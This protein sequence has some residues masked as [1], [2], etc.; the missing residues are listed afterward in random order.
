MN[1]E[2][3]AKLVGAASSQKIEWSY[4]GHSGCSPVLK[5]NL[6]NREITIL[7]T[8]EM[9]GAE[10]GS[11]QYYTSCSGC[12]GAGYI[13][14]NPTKVH[15]EQ[16]SWYRTDAGSVQ[17][18]IE[19]KL[20]PGWGIY[21]PT[22][23]GNSDKRGFAPDQ[24]D[25][26]VLSNGKNLLVD[27]L[28]WISGMIQELENGNIVGVEKKFHYLAPQHEQ[29]DRRWERENPVE[30][31]IRACDNVRSRAY[32]LLRFVDLSNVSSWTSGPTSWIE[33]VAGLRWHSPAEGYGKPQWIKLGFQDIPASYIDNLGFWDE[34]EL[35]ISLN[36]GWKSLGEGFVMR[37][38]GEK[39]QLGYENNVPQKLYEKIDEAKRGGMYIST[40]NYWPLVEFELEL[41]SLEFY[42][43]VPAAL[44]KLIEG[45]KNKVGEIRKDLFRSL[46][47][48]KLR[49]EQGRDLK[50]RMAEHSELVVTTED[51]FAVGNCVPG[52]EE[53]LKRFSLE[54]PKTLGELLAHRSIDE[55]LQNAYFRRVIER[56][57]NDGWSEQVAE[58][59]Y[60]AD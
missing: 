4:D 12:S 36:R 39:I 40:S 47:S 46:H 28:S 6:E 50:I 5:M 32:F 59:E 13:R 45:W 37:T 52:T 43:N 54:S 55:M 10:E 17:Q 35:P 11:K 41:S 24:E 58:E 60:C 9:L 51:S 21:V 23:N 38:R 57:L 19:S 2:K 48:E 53:F 29:V 33:E 7:S 22:R 14:F 3:I 30:Y 49:A 1:F 56:R 34:L 20:L 31:T 8:P 15:Y 42:Q 25:L 18:W 16:C 26:V 27:K 44:E